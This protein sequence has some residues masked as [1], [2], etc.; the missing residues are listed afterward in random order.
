ML[1]VKSFTLLNFFYVRF[2]IIKVVVCSVIADADDIT[3]LRAHIFSISVRMLSVTGSQKQK[4]L[5]KL[6]ENKLGFVRKL[7]N[8]FFFLRN[9]L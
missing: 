9:I 7:L 5:K 8:V 4:G 3:Y 2:L 1:R 6:V